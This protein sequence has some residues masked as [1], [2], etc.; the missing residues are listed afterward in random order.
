MGVQADLAIHILKAAFIEQGRKC[1]KHIFDTMKI[2]LTLQ[3]PET[4]KILCQLLPKLYIDEAGESRFRKMTLL[5]GNLENVGFDAD[6]NNNCIQWLI[7]SF[8]E[9][10]TARCH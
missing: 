6:I 7:V 5:S 3:C 2:L 9:K 10:H 1:L 8:I 4:R